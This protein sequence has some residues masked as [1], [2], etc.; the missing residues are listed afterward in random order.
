[1]VL[2]VLEAI[3]A[4]V[5]GF[6]GRVGASE[7]LE[8]VTLLPPRVA[9]LLPRPAGNTKHS[10]ANPATGLQAARMNSLSKASAASCDFLKSR[11]PKGYKL[12]NFTTLQARMKKSSARK[13][14]SFGFV[15]G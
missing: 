7:S 13:C 9:L 10:G 3:P 1:M 11:S 5:Q 2:V 12:G 15:L 14:V 8:G 6:R 4:K